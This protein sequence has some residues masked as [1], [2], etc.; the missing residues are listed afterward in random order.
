M[1]WTIVWTAKA[2]RQILK[3]D[4]LTARRI[5]RTIDRLAEDPERR[6]KRLVG[7]GLHR[8]RVGDWWVIV[9]LERGRLIVIVL[10]RGDRS[11]VYRN[12]P[13]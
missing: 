3:L 7:T 6:L 5:K 1:T 13:S 12:L 8:L 4:R 11:T 2:R 9:K 10:S